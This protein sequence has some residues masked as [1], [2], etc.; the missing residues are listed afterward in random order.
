MKTFVSILALLA[1]FA[2]VPAFAAENA[3]QPAPS[4][5]A[6]PSPACPSP[7]VDAVAVTQNN[8]VASW[9]LAKP[10]LWS[11][12]V[13]LPWLSAG[14]AGYCRTCEGCCAIL[15]PNSCACC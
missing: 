3:P 10:I 15:G 14:C 9:L 11:E 7:T 6:A 2:V 1:L 8:E 5:V 12:K 13:N 4:L